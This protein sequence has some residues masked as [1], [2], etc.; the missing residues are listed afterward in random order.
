MAGHKNLIENRPIFIDIDGTLTDKGTRDGNPI[1]DRIKRLKAMVAGGYQ[2]VVWS[3]T[4]TTYAVKFCKDNGITGVI[5]IGKP[6]YCVDDNPMIRPKSLRVESPE[7]F[8][9]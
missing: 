2:I 7:E 1:P 3:G 9:K 6:E 4:G 8:F 5:A